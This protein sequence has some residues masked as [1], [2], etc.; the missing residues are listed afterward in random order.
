[1]ALH[2]MDMPQDSH[3]HMQQQQSH[4]NHHHQQALAAA[5]Q[6]QHHHSQ[7][8]TAA[9][10]G[11]QGH[12]VPPS[13]H[14]APNMWN[15]APANL[16]FN[17]APPGGSD[18]D[19]DI[20]PLTSP[21]FGATPT[22]AAHRGPPHQYAP[23]P[24]GEGGRNAPRKRT[25]SP[26]EDGG[27][28]PSG[29]PM[30]KRSVVQAP[31]MRGSASGSGGATSAGQPPTAL[32]RTR[33]AMS[34]S[35]NST[36]ILRGN[37]RATRRGSTAT[38]VPALGDVPNDTP[39]PVDL[40]SMAMPPPA[41]PAPAPADTGGDG[42]MQ[43]GGQDGPPPLPMTISLTPVT[44]ASIMNLGRLGLQSG[45][46]PPPLSSV[47]EG[48]ASGQTSQGRGATT[49]ARAQSVGQTSAGGSRTKKGTATPNSAAF[50]HI[51]PGTS[52]LALFTVYYT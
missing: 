35:A 51:L 11:A 49:R 31:N 5:H 39:S 2:Y 37:A 30:R 14:M 22:Q 17:T 26:G 46:S 21:W 7:N 15:S 50:K 27:A 18:L 20:S 42:Q 25:A 10:S 52:I 1:M 44:P 41:A 4:Q 24:V 36:P 23:V 32:R 43:M 9:A 47:P 45:L 13:P 33:T 19:F 28:P 16:V 40:S 29:R 12:S 48:V 34:R 6:H 3:G 38:S 8:A